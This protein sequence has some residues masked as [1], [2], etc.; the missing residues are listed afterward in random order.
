[1]KFSSR[2]ARPTRSPRKLR[3]ES[4]ESRRVMAAAVDLTPDGLLSINGDADDNRIGVEV[5]GDRL[6]VHVDGRSADFNA[7]DVS[8]IFVQAGAGNDIVKIDSSVSLPTRL[9]GGLGND[10]LSGGSGPDLIEGNAGN[11][12]IKGNAGADLL[13]GGLGNDRVAGGRGDDYLAGGSGN[14]R[15]RGGLGNDWIFGDATNTYPEGA[16]DP[17]VYADTHAETNA[18]R[19]WIDGGKGRDTLYG[20]RGNDTLRGGAGRD[21]IAGG[22]GHDRVFAIDHTVDFILTDGFDRLRVDDADIIAIF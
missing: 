14:D 3:A 20:G 5:S 9:Y 11:D 13:F 4:L 2:R 18:G 1:M 22:T 6:R 8:L 21:F 10:R 17:Q 15:L 16:V 19:D 7:K 12:R